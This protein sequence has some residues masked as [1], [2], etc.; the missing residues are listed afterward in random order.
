MRNEN[1]CNIDT[2]NNAS[3]NDIIW[4]HP[5]CSGS[6]CRV[7]IGDYVLHYLNELT[8]RDEVLNSINTANT[9]SLYIGDREGYTA[10]VNTIASSIAITSSVA[11]NTYFSALRCC[12]MNNGRIWMGLHR[13]RRNRASKRSHWF[14]YVKAGGKGDH[15]VF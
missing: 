12:G 4:I 6:G 8:L 7:N 1:Y 5:T 14:R 2:Q 10:E 11:R 3:T 13:W 15:R 9:A